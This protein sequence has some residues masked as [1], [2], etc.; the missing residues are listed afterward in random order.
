M[1]SLIF[2]LLP[3]AVLVLSFGHSHGGLSPGHMLLHALTV[4]IASVLLYFAAAAYYRV[5][6]P[7]FKWLFSGFLLLLARELVLS[8]SMYTYTDIYVPYTD[9]PLDHMLGLAA[10]ITLAYAIFKQF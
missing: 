6:T 3:I 4:I 5:K 7:R 2:L 8:I 9:I 10:L 1:R